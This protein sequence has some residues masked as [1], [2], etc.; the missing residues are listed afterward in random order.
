MS[1]GVSFLETMQGH[2]EDRW[3]RTHSI[4]F[5]IKA[6]AQRWRRFARDGRT[7][8]T[9]ILHAPPWA[10]HLPVEGTLEVS[11]IKRHIRYHMDF[12]VEG[13][14][15][16][17][18]G[19]KTIRWLR[20][21]K[22]LTQM[23]VELS[24]EGEKLAQGEVRF[25][26]N[27][28]FGFAA[29]W[30]IN[31]VRPTPSVRRA[32]HHE[33]AAL[34]SLRA[35]D[36]DRLL[37][38][39]DVMIVPGEHVPAADEQTLQRLDT[40]LGRVAA[41]VARGYGHGLAALDLMARLRHG[42]SLSTLSYEKRCALLRS[43]HQSNLPE[44][45]GSAL[46]NAA[47]GLSTWIKSAH[48]GR[49]DYLA[50]IGYP[51]R[52]E[53][54]NPEPPARYLRQVTSAAALEPRTRVEADVVVVG[55]GAG[56]AAVAASLA[57]QGH[58][59]VIV[60][61]GPYGQ[62]H[63]FTGGAMER[64]QRL[65]RQGATSFSVGRPPIA[66]PLGKLVGGST[67]INSGTCLRPKTTVLDAWRK[68][69]GFPSDFSLTGLAPYLHVVEREL[70]VA[71]ADKRY[72]GA[73][74]DVVARGAEAMG[75]SHYPLTRNAP[76]CDGQGS[77][78]FGCPTGAK[79]STN[80][81]FVP[82]ALRA[83]AMLYTGLPVTRILKRGRRVQ[84]VLAEGTDSYG[85]TKRLEILARAVVVSCGAVGS[86]VLLAENGWRNPWLGKNLSLHPAL[87]MWGLCDEPLEPWQAIPQGYGV[88]VQQEGICFE[89]FY[90]PP[91]MAALSMPLWGEELTRWSDNHARL[92]QFGFMVQD[93]SPGSV[94]ATP[95]GT[96][97][98]RYELSKRSRQLL[99]R[100]AAILA[101][102][103]LAGG[104]SEVLP[105]ISGHQ[106]I[107]RSLA[108]AR[109]LASASIAPMDFHLLGAHPLG[110]CRLGASAAE[111]V[112]DFS[113]RVFGTENLYVV[114]G[115]N[116]PTALGVNPQVTI[117]TLAL[118]AADIIGATLE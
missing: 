21:V 83:G 96:P 47:F 18:R 118:R 31:D 29:S 107:V 64:S 62:R 46:R 22:T 61:E 17:L 36:R 109:G 38:L 48:F 1:T 49:P 26:L 37:S 94:H 78:I 15:F 113:H 102:L 41:N 105:A 53:V 25:D 56:G 19:E 35:R 114:D 90:L 11:L 5:E 89:G 66:I 103:L 52:T 111:G 57:A 42:K 86:P 75:F 16:E 6:R 93:D 85:A 58:A 63:D 99:Q 45:L 95:W 98:V 77:C 68:E 39:V 81:S 116:V 55:T 69:R 2:L 79:R 67:A 33:T 14:S 7:R 117:M 108:Q 27:Q 24:R 32:L 4:D 100:G 44:P 12:N 43:L 110:T 23:R 51:L 3:G 70:Q 30:S 104:A 88:D 115:S 91:E 80:T 76:D 112:V 72:L 73:I 60:E 8:F 97:L 10:D 71:P 106:P 28:V 84:G 101:E 54:Q 13:Q 40:N 87:G 50:S 65:W 92:A 59:V 20:A 82:R 34:S 74:A 9:G